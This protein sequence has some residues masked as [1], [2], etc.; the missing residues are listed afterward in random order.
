MINDSI[1]EANLLFQE[2]EAW[3]LLIIEKLPSIAIGGAVLFLCYVISGPLG[4]ILAKPLT[5]R[6]SSK[7]IKLVTQRLISWLI[8]LFGVYIFLKMVGLSDF[9]VAI[10]SVTGVAGIIIGFAFRDIAENFLA[11]LLLS[12]QKP[13]RLGEV[14]EVN[15]QIGVIKHVTARAT[16][17]IDFDGNHI[18]IPNA[19]VYKNTIRNF[20]ANPNTRIHFDVG[21]GYDSSPEEAQLVCLD[22]IEKSE[23][24]LSTPEPQVLI[25]KLDSS[26]YQLRVYFWIDTRQYSLF[27]AKSMMMKLVT[28]ACL[29][30]GFSM[31]DP[32]RER[33]FPE[34]IELIRKSKSPKQVS[35]KVEATQQISPRQN[36]ISKVEDV[37]ND[38]S[39]EKEAEKAPTTEVG[40]NIL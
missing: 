14:I 26:C 7:L 8:T 40:Q 6:H 33:V 2:A 30:A 27:K 23:Y 17:L 21:I 28:K 36:E 25:E 15:G 24:V 18:Q 11:S 32:D 29:E 16:T 19:T 9:A 34:G 13:F 4:T 1:N 37:K 39:I 10:L 38:K 3:Y 35:D 20:S 5:Y 31:P 22:V 12:I